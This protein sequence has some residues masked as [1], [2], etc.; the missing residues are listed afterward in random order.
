M[1]SI[2]GGVT[3]S[4]IFR[5]ASAHGVKYVLNLYGLQECSLLCM[6]FSSLAHSHVAITA[7][8]ISNNAPSTINHTSSNSSCIAYKITKLFKFFLVSSQCEQTIVPYIL[9]GNRCLL[10]M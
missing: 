9:H 4:S 1:C 3:L 6:A 2:I 5:R 10:W 7:I 8:F